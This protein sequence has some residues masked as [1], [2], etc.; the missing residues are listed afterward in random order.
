MSNMF[1][2]S[3]ETSDRLG[4]NICHTY[5]AEKIS[6]WTIRHTYKNGKLK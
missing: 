3:S 1:K 2:C 5:N 6:L 4:D